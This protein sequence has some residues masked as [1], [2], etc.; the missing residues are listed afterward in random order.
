MEDPF[1]GLQQGDAARR[2]AAEEALE[3]RRQKELMA[4]VERAKAEAEALG[5]DGPAQV[6]FRE[7]S[8]AI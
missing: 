6:R 4:Q 8:T 1:K 5:E 2:A 7:C 3:L